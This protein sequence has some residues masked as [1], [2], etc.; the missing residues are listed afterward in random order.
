MSETDEHRTKGN[1]YNLPQ[2]KQRGE[3]HNN[4]PSM[5]ACSAP[6]H[7]TLTLWEVLKINKEKEKHSERQ[8]GGAV[9]NNHPPPEPELLLCLF[10]CVK[11]FDCRRWWV[12]CVVAVWACI[13]LT[14]ACASVSLCLHQS[15]IQ[16]GPLRAGGEP[17]LWLNGG[18]RGTRS[19]ALIEHTSVCLKG[20]KEEISHCDLASHEL[21][22]CQ[23]GVFKCSLF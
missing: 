23:Q 5:E 11:P 10:V 13:P 4:T 19:M 2:V 16:P 14:L 18:L 15:G 12:G 20:S 6:C 9:N 1:K 3:T 21:L 8:N 22:N 7:L 17:A